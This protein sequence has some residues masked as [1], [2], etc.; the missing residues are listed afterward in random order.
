MKVLIAEAKHCPVMS[1][2]RKLLDKHS[3]VQCHREFIASSFDVKNTIT[4]ECKCCYACIN[5][6]A[7][8]GCSNCIEFL[9]SYMP[10]K[11]AKIKLS[12]SVA[13]DLKESLLELFQALS[14]KEVKIEDHLS[15]SH[16]SFICDFIRMID[17]IKNPSDICQMWRVN[18]ELAGWIFSTVQE[19]LYSDVYILEEESFEDTEVDEYQDD[20]SDESSEDE[21]EAITMSNLHLFTNE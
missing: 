6:H 18:A 21:V 3:V 12:K 2:C 9:E 5:L 13:K 1:E 10:S 14:L 16:E 8:G 19:V 20:V 15:V 17:E 11:E 4:D 7:E